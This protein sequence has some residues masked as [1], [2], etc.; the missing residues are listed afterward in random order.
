MARLVDVYTVECRST[1]TC[2]TCGIHKP[3]DQ[4]NKGRAYCKP[5]HSASALAWSRANRE[6]RRAIANAYTKRRREKLGP[7]KKGGRR[8]FSAEESAKRDRESKR[9]W[10]K[11]N[12]ARVLA[13]TR[14]YQAKK[15]N[16][17]PK[18]A[19]RMAIEAIYEEARRTGSHVD[20]IVPLQSKI[21]CGLHCEAN[22]QILTPLENWS[23]NNRRWP[24]MP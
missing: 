5:C 17:I 9:R 20:H 12:Y 13:K 8:L 15:L 19:D 24:D 16:A 3:L 6:K 23:K 7:P 18:W 10:E 22:L 4:F 11:N 2:T 21:V 14:A 1:K